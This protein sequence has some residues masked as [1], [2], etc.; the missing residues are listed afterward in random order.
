MTKGGE[1]ECV[2]DLGFLFPASSVGAEIELSHF[3]ART[4]GGWDD[5][6]QYELQMK[7]R[8]SK[9]CTTV[10]H[11]GY[12]PHFGGGDNL[13]NHSGKVCEFHKPLLYHLCFRPFCSVCVVFILRKKMRAHQH[14]LILVCKVWGVQF[15][16]ILLNKNAEADKGQGDSAITLSFS[17]P[18]WTYL[19]KHNIDICGSKIHLKGLANLVLKWLFNQ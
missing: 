7:Q 15:N 9:K 11:N 19:K 1:T 17:I 6:V 2:I 13:A 10:A 8:S 16:A 5:S 3:S 18:L 4:G 12:P 14:S